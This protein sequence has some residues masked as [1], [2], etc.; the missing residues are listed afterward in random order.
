VADGSLAVIYVKDLE[1]KYLFVNRRFEEL[2]HVR[3]DEMAGK[4]DYDLFP[5]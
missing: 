5:K 4:T 1:G 3:R 2:F